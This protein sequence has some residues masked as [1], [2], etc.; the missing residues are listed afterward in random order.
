MA[1]YFDDLN[2]KHNDRKKPRY[3]ANL[4]DF[5]APSGSSHVQPVE[6]MQQMLQ[7]ATFF[8]QFRQQMANQGNAD[9][10]QFLDNI[11]SQLLEESQSE[12]KGPPP[13]SQRFIANLPTVNKRSLDKEETCIICKD[14]LYTSSTKVTRMPCGHHFDEDC[15]VPWLSLHHTCP[16][17]RHKVESEQVA[18]EEEEEES[19]G[20]M[21]G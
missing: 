13:A 14:I 6:S 8:D 12:A 5:M 9:Q 21:Y 19:R 10:E 15:L 2:I 4:D 7:T 16:L 11:V 18:K 20:W 1:S 17:C 3:D